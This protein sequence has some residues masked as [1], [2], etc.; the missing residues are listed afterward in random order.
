MAD[1]MQSTERKA[2]TAN[3]MTLAQ[4]MAG[5][6]WL[7][8]C[9]ELAATQPHGKTARALGEFLG[10]PVTVGNLGTL[11]AA[12][13]VRLH[14]SCRRL[15]G[16]CGRQEVEA[17]RVSMTNLQ[18]EVRRIMEKLA[19]RVTALEALQAAGYQTA[20]KAAAAATAKGEM[21]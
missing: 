17:L 15:E 7:K 12:A 13:G 20:E 11:A 14:G 18:D 21:P 19:Q 1:A 16:D 9:P 8:E 4:Q 6:A 2:R 10:R 5:V 3:R